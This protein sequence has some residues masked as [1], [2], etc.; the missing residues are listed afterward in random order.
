MTDKFIEVKNGNDLHIT[1]G[2]DDWQ[3]I[4][5][6][7]ELHLHIRTDNSGA[8]SIDTYKYSELEEPSENDLINSF[9]VDR[10]DLITEITVTGINNEPFYEYY[11]LGNK[12][13]ADEE[14][15]GENIKDTDTIVR[16]I[17]RTSPKVINSS[18]HKIELEGE[19]IFE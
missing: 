1:M 3:E 7:N 16:L 8:Y 17:K 14:V 2:K 10:D 5:I 19:T 12:L 15:I 4:V 11:L 13:Y 6:N 18:V 9:W